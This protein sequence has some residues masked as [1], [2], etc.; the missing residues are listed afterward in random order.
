M[1]QQTQVSTVLRYYDRFLQRFPTVS[2]LAEAAEDDVLGLWSGL[3][4]YSR[5]RNL[6]RCAQA[7]VSGHGG[8]FPR[9]AERLATLPGIGD[10]TAA[11]IASFCFGERVSILDGNVRRVLTRW[12]GFGDD[13]SKPS[14]TRQLWDVAQSLLPEQPVADDMAA[15]TQGLM[16]LGATLCTRSRPACEKCPMASDCVGWMQGDPTRYPVRVRKIQRK[17]ERWFLLLALA[18]DRLSNSGQPD[19]LVLLE[20]RPSKGIWASLHS[21]PVFQSEDE[22]GTLLAAMGARI[23]QADVLT[24]R[25]HAL[26]HRDLYLMP[27]QLALGKPVELP[28]P[29]RWMPLVDALTL[30]LP[31]PVR[32]LLES[33]SVESS[34]T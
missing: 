16:D 1:L 17:Q 4:Y 34:R 19:P 23:S 32:T 20:K 24:P 14:A 12:L 30:G 25:Q 6:H 33:V 2:S 31:A 21:V 15:Y 10:S 9:T 28:Q 13:V 26:T 22:L 29:Y 5:A 11:A 18:T 27:Y 8:E 3:G 7:V